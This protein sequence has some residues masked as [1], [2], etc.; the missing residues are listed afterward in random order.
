MRL[1]P[2][3]ARNTKESERIE[4]DLKKQ[5]CHW[6]ITFCA[7]CGFNYDIAIYAGE[8]NSP[9]QEL[10]KYSWPPPSPPDPPIDPNRKFW[11]Y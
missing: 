2:R 9:Q 4:K 3:C 7:S 5:D 10:D 1:C 8:I 6:L 11:G